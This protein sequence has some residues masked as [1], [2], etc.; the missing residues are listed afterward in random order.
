VRNA[1]IES[2]EQ[3]CPVIVEAR[4][5][6]PDSGGP[7]KYRGGLG[8]R[9]QVRAL[10]EGRWGLPP[11]RRNTYPP[12]GLWG[13]KPGRGGSNWVKT[14]ED[15]EWKPTGIYRLPVTKQAVIR[16]ET[17]G[18]G[19][20]GDPL[21]RDPQM[22]LTDF[23]NGYISRQGARDDYGVVIDDR[24]LIDLKATDALRQTMRAETK[25]KPG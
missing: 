7:G 19:G 3:K 10:E 24:D 22:V 25:S 1:P 16:A 14:P 4:E 2:I 20:W 23:L 9:L 12:W 6:R 21:E 11:H 5:L 17:T 18:G 13:G 8:L 15:Q